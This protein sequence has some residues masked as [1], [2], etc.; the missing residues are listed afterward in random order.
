MITLEEIAGRLKDKTDY[1]FTVNR[2]SWEPQKV[3]NYALPTFTIKE[4]KAKGA[5]TKLKNKLSKVL[6]F[7][8]S[9]KHKRFK[10]GCTVM[11]ISVTNKDMLAIWENEMGVSRAIA[12]MIEIGL[13]SIENDKYQFNAY[14][15]KDNKSKT[16]RYYKE[17]EDKI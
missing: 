15:N 7:I 1:T 16:Y 12:Y 8:D 5:E 10:T 17:N 2:M 9:V 13:I 11:P 6:A 4:S 3:D 14:H